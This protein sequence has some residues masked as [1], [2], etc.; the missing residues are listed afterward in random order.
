MKKVLVL[1]LVLAVSMG[2][3]LTYARSQSSAIIELNGDYTW[4]WVGGS[5]TSLIITNTPGA[6][7]T[8]WIIT[9]TVP[10]ILTNTP[11]QEVVTLTPTD[12]PDPL[13]LLQNQIGTIRVRNLPST[14]DTVTL[15][16]TFNGDYIHPL[17]YYEDSV[18]KWYKITWDENTEGWTADTTL[19]TYISGDCAGLLYENPF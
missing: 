1:L 4:N 18:R 12:T 9:A 8:P 6:T 5:P 2:I 13:C 11:T 14:Q 7:Q 3:V 17:A 10:T 16:Y 15:G 19:Y